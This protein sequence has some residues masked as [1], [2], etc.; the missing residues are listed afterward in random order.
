LTPREV[1]DPD[2]D[3]VVGPADN[4]PYLAS[5]DFADSDRDGLGDACDEAT[6]AK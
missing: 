1:R 5:R 2:R 3:G 6:V 4:C